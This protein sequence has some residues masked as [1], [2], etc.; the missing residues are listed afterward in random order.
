MVNEIVK[1]VC[2]IPAEEFD[3]VH[4]DCFEV[5]KEDVHIRIPLYKSIIA[6]TFDSKQIIIREESD[7]F[8]IFRAGLKRLLDEKLNTEYNG[9]LL[10]IHNQL[11]K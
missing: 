2:S 11:I 3:F 4:N 7:E 6:L 10:K 1:Y 5:T 9:T 8:M